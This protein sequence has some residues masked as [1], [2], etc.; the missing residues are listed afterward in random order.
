MLMRYLRLYGAFLA[1]HVKGLMAHRLNFLIGSLSTLVWQGF[2]ILA[3]WIVLEQAPDLNGWSQGEI[4][5]V[6]G[7]GTMALA[8]AG[9]FGVNLLYIGQGYVRTGRFDLLLI[10]PV[11]PL[12]HLLAD[13]FGQE[14]IGNL[15]AGALLVGYGLR[16]LGLEPG[17]LEW[18]YLVAVVAAGGLLFMA[19]DLITAVT[20]FWIIVATPV[21]LALNHATQIARFPLDI[22]RK[23]LRLL[24]TWVIPYGLASHYPAQLI[25][26]R[27]A[28]LMPYTLFPMAALLFYL[29]YRFW[30]YG[31]TRYTSTGS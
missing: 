13:R 19:L 10:R 23:P 1:Q 11:N 3:V 20:A 26:G 21:T 22:Y 14:G 6:Y 8:V 4:F 12:F 29:A 27:P 17:P 16:S 9:I 5:L 24:M 30:L 25:L 7:L 31:L 28:G 2:G 15:L 18:G